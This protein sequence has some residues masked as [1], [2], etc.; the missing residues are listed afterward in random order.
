[1]AMLRLNYKGGAGAERRVERKSGGVGAM[2]VDV[3]RRSAYRWRSPPLRWLAIP[4]QR[5]AIAPEANTIMSTAVKTRNFLLL[6][7]VAATAACGSSNAD[8]SGP[9]AA[10]AR[11][12]ARTAV[13]AEQMRA[14]QS[15]SLSGGTPVTEGKDYA[16]SLGCASSLGLLMNNI[17]NSP[18]IDD[19]QVT[20]LKSAYE[21]F[22]TRAFDAGSAAGKSRQQ[23]NVDLERASEEAQDD[24]A[25]SSRKAIGC[26]R[27]LVSEAQRTG[28]AGA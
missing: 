12:T 1:M 7:L 16:G 8:G 4:L 9:A 3:R 26:V 19:A 18:L 13:S 24:T 6:G 5:H 14:A 15:L 21:L 20:A 2:P 22:R 23:V 10:V 27:G 17:E 28:G 11:E 25:A